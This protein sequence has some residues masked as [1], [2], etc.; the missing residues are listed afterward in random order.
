[1]L[2]HALVQTSPFRALAHY[3]ILPA[4]VGWPELIIAFVARAPYAMVPLGTMTAI[5]ASTGSVATGGLA[6]GVVSLSTAIA[7][8]LIGRWADLG[9]QRP[10]LLTLLPLNALSL[11]GLCAVALTA[12]SGLGLWLAALCVGLTAVPIGSFTRARWVARTTSPHHLAAA[13]SYESTADEFVFV[14]GPALVGIAASAA[15]PAAPLALAVLLVLCAGIPFAIRTPASLPNEDDA[16]RTQTPPVSIASVLRVVLPA[17]LIMACIGTIFGSV[18]AGTTQ[19]AAMAGMQTQ[20]GLIY[21]VM[22][23]GSAAM[24]LMV[25]LIPESVRLSWR[26]IIGGVGIAAAMGA[27]AGASSIIL[28]ALMLLIAGLFVGPTMVTAFSLSERLAPPQGVSVAMTSMQ[29]SVTIG[30]SC[31]SAAGGMMAS[32][33]GAPWAYAIA[34]CAGLVIALTGEILRRAGSRGPA[35]LQS[36]VG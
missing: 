18:Q 19:R 36:Q 35:R 25:V 27:T 8:P 20:A 14:L 30:V 33:S 22:G 29:S 10:V 24:A 12:H 3:R 2:G 34:V 5:T 32:S 1:M 9:G 6:T 16:D 13:F 11:T 23:I 21:A 7:S 4:L 26:V 31:G 15:A 17:I 28:T